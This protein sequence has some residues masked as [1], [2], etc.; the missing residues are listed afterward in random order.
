MFVLTN[1]FT[2]KSKNNP[3]KKPIGFSDGSPLVAG[4]GL[5]PVTFGL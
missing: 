5:E 1:S 4:T 2:D 3:N